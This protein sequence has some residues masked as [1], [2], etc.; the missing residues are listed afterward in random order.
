MR[1]DDLVDILYHLGPTK[2]ECPQIYI[3]KG[4]GVP[5]SL[6]DPSLC[7]Y[8]RKDEIADLIVRVV[9]F[10]GSVVK[11][12]EPSFDYT[13]SGTRVRPISVYVKVRRLLSKNTTEDDG[14]QDWPWLSDRQ[15]NLIQ[16]PPSLSGII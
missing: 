1:H 11:G 13:Y 5:P 10:R 2:L 7:Y 3:E 9:E 4:V 8:F 6:V 16:H 14:S 15:L 12:E